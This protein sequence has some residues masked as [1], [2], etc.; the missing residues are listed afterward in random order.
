M[1]STDNANSNKIVLPVYCSDLVVVDIQRRFVRI[2][3]QKIISAIFIDVDDPNT[4]PIAFGIQARV[5]GHVYER[6]RIRF[7]EHTVTF[8]TTE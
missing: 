3:N 6:A 1:V 2:G 8:R 5:A 7:Q 4:S